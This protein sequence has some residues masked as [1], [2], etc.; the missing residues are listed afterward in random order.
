MREQLRNQKLLDD[1]DPFVQE[2]NAKREEYDKYAQYIQSGDETLV[3][4]ADVAFSDLLKE[5]STYLEY[6]RRKKEELQGKIDMGI[7]V[8][9]SMEVLDAAISQAESGKSASDM[10][11]ESLK[12]TFSSVSSS[13]DLVKGAF[14]AVTG[15]LDKF[16]I[17]MDEE[18]QAILNDIGGMIEGASQLSQGIATGNPLSVIQ[19]SI[20]LLSSVFDLFNFRDRKA[21]RSIKKHKK[22][23]E[24]LE[25]A[26]KQLEWQIGRA[27]GGEVYA[28]QQAAIRNMQM[29]QQELRGMIE[30]EKSKKKTD[31]DDIRKYE[32]QI[33]ELDRNI[34]DMLDEIAKDILQTTAKDMANE[35][36]DA[37]VEAFGKGED[38]AQA[39]EKTVNEVLKNAV[40]NQLKKNFLEKQLQGAL[41]QLE[42]SMGYWN[43]DNFI[44]D[45]LTDYEINQFKSRVQGIANTFNQAM[46]AYSDIFK[47]LDLVEKEDDTLTGAVKGVSE[48]TA[49]IIGGQM[50]AIRL[51]QVEVAT[52]MRQQLSVLSAIQRNTSYNFHL[53]K[54]TRILEILEANNGNDT[55]RANGLA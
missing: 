15:S 26:Y 27:L 52:I 51:N 29:Q 22:E 46:G 40:L 35:L 47:D 38:A 36:G 13:L 16:G 48:E 31:W 43:G 8:G 49:S 11:R 45:G 12:N 53:G 6:L 14:D 7:D 54:L 41:D 17:E 2:L 39:F 30:D 28:N 55:N 42:E 33:A 20:G 34:Q 21:Q 4:G 18:S 10:M 50:N 19:G 44:F 5:G 24:R 9:N 3:K 25:N 1:N 37:L 23:I 32:E